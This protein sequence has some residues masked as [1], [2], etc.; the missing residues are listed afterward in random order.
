MFRAH[1]YV[2]QGHYADVSTGCR[3]FHMCNLD[4]SKSSFVCGNG[5]LFDQ[6]HTVCQWAD[7]VDCAKSQLFYPSTHR[8]GVTTTQGPRTQIPTPVSPAST[9]T[10][11]PKKLMQGMPA[12]APGFVPGQPNIAMGSLDAGR[13]IKDDDRNLR[14]FGLFAPPHIRPQLQRSQFK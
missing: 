12:S 4:G 3:V 2:T 1:L 7:D 13:S 9:T 10:Q 5:T 14:P 6:T 8:P 11:S